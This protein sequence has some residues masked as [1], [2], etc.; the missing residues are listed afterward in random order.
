MSNEKRI[1][2]AFVRTEMEKFMKDKDMSLNES[3]DYILNNLQD[4]ECK[5]C[6]KV[7]SNS[8]ADKIKKQGVSFKERDMTSKEMKK[9][10]DDVSKKTDIN[11]EVS[12]VHDIIAKTTSVIISSLM[13]KYNF[14]IDKKFDDFYLSDNTD[15]EN[16][17]EE[18]FKAISKPLDKILNKAAEDSNDPYEYRDK[19][20]G[21]MSTIIMRIMYTVNDMYE[22]SCKF[23]DKI[24]KDLVYFDNMQKINNK[25]KEKKNVR[26][27][28]SMFDTINRIE[29]DETNESFKDFLRKLNE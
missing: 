28:K 6:Y 17:D 1:N 25:F 29:K 13:D 20:I 21:A 5:K 24:N 3:V 2:I 27:E 26:K 19:Y 22:A 15:I 12:I 23:A 4:P 18:L 8:E 11:K 10:E 9:L 16:L 7:L 14:S